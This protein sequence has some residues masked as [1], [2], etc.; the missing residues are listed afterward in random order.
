MCRSS[1]DKCLFNS[2]SQVS[3]NMHERDFKDGSGF[4][5]ISVIYRNLL[6]DAHKKRYCVSVSLS[7]KKHKWLLIGGI[8]KHYL[9]TESHDAAGDANH[10]TMNVAS[11]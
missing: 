9:S 6:N 1:V 3:V 2:E 10:T 4:R 11:K 8:I 7:R 5:D